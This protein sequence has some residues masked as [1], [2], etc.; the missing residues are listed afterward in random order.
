M[1]S[2]YRTRNNST[3]KEWRLS[4]WPDVEIGMR[5][6]CLGGKTRQLHEDYGFGITVSSRHRTWMPGVSPRVPALADRWQYQTHRLISSLCAA[7]WPLADRAS[8]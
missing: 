6:S 7:P 8:L 1:C 4:A 3:K 5:A 2:G